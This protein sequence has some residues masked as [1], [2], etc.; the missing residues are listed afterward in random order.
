MIHY[1]VLVLLTIYLLIK[2]VKGSLVVVLF[3]PILWAFPSYVFS[4]LAYMMIVLSFKVIKLNKFFGQI[5]WIPVIFM[6]LS[7]IITNY[8][9]STPHSKLLLNRLSFLY[10]VPLVSYYLNKFGYT[11]SFCIRCLIV[12]SVIVIIYG[13][14]E[15]IVGRNP[16][17]DFFF[18][19]GIYTD[20]AGIINN[21]MRYG[22]R[23]INSLFP[24][25]ISLGAFSLMVSYILMHITNIMASNTMRLGIV[26]GLV[27]CALFTGSR[28]IILSMVICLFSLVNVKKTNYFK[29]MILGMGVF[30]LFGSVLQNIYDSIIDTNVVSGSN[31]DM[32]VSQ[33]DIGL[34]Y[35][36]MSPLFG[37]GLN[38]TWEVA[39]PNNSELLGAESVWLPLMIEQGIMGCLAWLTYHLFI[40]YEAIKKKL[41]F[42]IFLILAVV[43][44]YTMTSVPGVNIYFVMLIYLIIIHSNKKSV[45][46]PKMNN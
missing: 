44:L 21:D 42:L 45:D 40:C 28:A 36:Y 23:R 20:S 3:S 39:L 1:L 6:A 8:Y 10:L 34:Y 18:S 26:L 38:Y 27:M 12:F 4:T 32:R 13:F 43:L 17:T 24:V 35:L 29:I 15:L 5:I 37:N 31:S 7:Y 16:I 46:T 22:F 41:Y 11:V 19:T 2:P 14:I 30:F 25:H 33:F 9:S